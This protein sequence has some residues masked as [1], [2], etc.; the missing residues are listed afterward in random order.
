MIP[1]RHRETL[2]LANRVRRS[3][4]EL[5]RDSLDQQLIN[6]ALAASYHQFA[7]AGDSYPFVEKRELKPRARTADKEYKRHN[8]FL[9][10]FTEDVILPKHKKYLHFFDHNKT[11]LRNLKRS[12][13]VDLSLCFNRDSK[14]FDAP[15]FYHFM[16]ALLPVDYALLI[17][18]HP[19]SRMVNRY[20]LT[21]YHVRVDWPILDAAEE[22]GKNLRYLSKDL[23]EKG[24]HYAENLLRKFFEYYGL[25]PMSGG[26]RTAAIIAAQYVKKLGCMATVYV[27]SSESRSMMRFCERGVTKSVLVRLSKE[28]IKEIAAI[29]HLTP[30]MLRKKYTIAATRRHGLG[31]LQAR[32]N[33]TE[34]ART[35]EDGKIRELTADLN[36]L[37][38]SEQY[39][40]PRPGV[41]QFPPLPVNLIYT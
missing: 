25:T 20:N 13:S 22:L 15:D 2:S 16:E 38:V 11:T 37:T 17:Q 12:R 18:R 19:T 10:I 14:F 21:H 6:H 24:D 41:R 30:A 39:L 34:P 28:K 40:L 36:W 32:Y 26:R 31:I 1:W 3:Y 33:H 7:K 5:L 29:H 27:G 23:Y 35:P 9:V 4:Y 8:T